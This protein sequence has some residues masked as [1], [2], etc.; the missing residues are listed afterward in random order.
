MPFRVLGLDLIDLAGVCYLLAPSSP[1]R[2][3]QKGAEM[4]RLTDRSTVTE[5][6]SPPGGIELPPLREPESLEMD[7]PNVS[8]SGA[9]VMTSEELAAAGSGPTPPAP[10]LDRFGDR[11]SHMT[12]RFVLSGSTEAYRISRFQSAKPPIEFPVTDEG[13]ARAWATFRE[14]EGQTA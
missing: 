12:D 4:S 6:P 8:S 7:P 10:K 9:T 2:P 13:W 11:V 5:H 1:E 14:L 3:F